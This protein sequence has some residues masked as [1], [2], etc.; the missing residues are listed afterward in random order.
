MT[1]CAATGAVARAAQVVIVDADTKNEIDDPFAIFRALAATELEVVGLTSEG[2]VQPSDPARVA[3]SHRANREIVAKMGL[4]GTV[5]CAIGATSSMPNRHTPVD[6]PAAQLIISTARTLPAGQKL[7]VVTTGQLTN[8]ASALLLDP[9]IEPR[10]AAYVVA[11]KL[12]AGRLTTDEFNCQGD[13]HAAACVLASGVELYVMPANTAGAYVVDKATVDRHFR[14]RGGIKDYLVRFWES[15]APGQ[16]HR[17]LWD[18]ALVEA[19]LNPG[20]ATLSTITQGGR[21]IRAWTAID[22]RAMESDYWAAADAFDARAAAMPLTW[23]SDFSRGMRGWRL[24]RGAM[25]KREGARMYVRLVGPTEG[26]IADCMSPLLQLDGAEHEYEL[27]CT[28]RT[29][30]QRSG[31]HS[32]AW[33]IFY[34]LDGDEKSIG[35]WTGLTLKKSARWTTAKATVEI[36]TGTRTFKTAIRIQGRKGKLLDVRTVSLRRI[37]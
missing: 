20:A 26:D 16:T 13:P 7:H 17:T 12:A 21:S 35:T 8:L 4:A 10:I 27:A 3:A 32:G 30:I 2:W 31:L 28:Y 14:T 33:F 5:T 36:P 23:D 1:L 18:V 19:Y 37:R 9:K 24:G 6:S 22:K 29:D 15:G 34:K 11:Y 25:L